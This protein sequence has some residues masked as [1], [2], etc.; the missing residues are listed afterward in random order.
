[1]CADS[2]GIENKGHGWEFTPAAKAA[3]RCK[4]LIAAL[5]ALR[6]LNSGKPDS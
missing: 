5:E 1:M 3:T 2:Y 4:R 6:H